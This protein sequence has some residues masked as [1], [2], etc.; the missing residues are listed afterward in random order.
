MAGIEFKMFRLLRKYILDYNLK[1]QMKS[2]KNESI[3]FNPS[4]NRKELSYKTHYI[5]AIFCSV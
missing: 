5:V 2:F 1:R 3:K 4:G